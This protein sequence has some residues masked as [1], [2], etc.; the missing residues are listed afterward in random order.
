[1]GGRFDAT[2]IIDMDGS[3]KIACGVTLLDLDHTR[4]LGDTLEQIAWEKG[5]IF[6]V[7]KGSRHPSSP[8]PSMQINEIMMAPAKAQSEKEIFF[9]IRT[10]IPSVLKVLE[11]CAAI[12]GEGRRLAIVGGDPVLDGIEIGLQGSHQLINASLAIALCDAVVG[13]RMAIKSETHRDMLMQALRYASWPGRCQSVIVDD[14]QMTVRLDGA[15][16]PKSLEA[17]VDWFRAQTKDCAARHV[18]IFNCS[19]ERNPVPL[20]QQLHSLHCFERI[21]FCLADFER[22]SGIGKPK[23][24]VLLAQEGLT[25]GED[26]QAATA[27]EYV[28]PTWQETLSEIWT[29]LD[30]K[31]NRETLIEVNLN[32]KQ[33][34]EQIRSHYSRIDVL[35][36]G[37]LYL[38]GS[39]LSTL[40]WHESDASGRLILP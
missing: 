20:L 3:R 26:D 27:N 16:T 19:H 38:V 24:A 6:Q 31:E 23:A 32:V 4:V 5:G 2:N 17:C 25:V 1:M 11:M 8:R 22:P 29:Y 14:H 13:D 12:E 30:R 18:L 35:V 15:H 9:A 7:Q 36:S 39:A 21:Y 34:M 40:G 28:A 33:A 10:N 37:S